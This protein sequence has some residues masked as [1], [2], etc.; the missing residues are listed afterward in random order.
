M[1]ILSTVASPRRTRALAWGILPVLFATLGSDYGR[2]QE[3]ATKPEAV[4]LSSLRL[5]KI[6][7]VV[8]GSVDRCEIAGAV[9]LV[10][11]HGQVVWLRANGQQDREHAK[12]MRTDSIF[13]ICSMTKPIV[14]L[15]VMLLYE[16]GRFQLDDPISKYIPEF[17]DP[18]VLVVP[19]EGKPYTIPATRPITIRHLLTHTS[20][21]TYN[22]D[23]VLGSDYKEAH[24]ASGLLP[25]E[26]TIGESVKRLARLPLLFHPG[27][28]WNYGL[29]IDV[30]GYLIEVVS[31]QPLDQFLQQ[32]I[33]EPLGMPDTFFYVPPDK[34]D[35]L[36][37]AYTWSEGK[38]LARFPDTPIT[39]GAFSYSAD[40][41]V[42]GPKKLFSGGAGL[43]STASDYARFCQLMLNHGKVGQTQRISR[44]SVELMTHDQLGPKF[45]EQAFGLGF[46]IDGVK[47]PLQELGSTG[48]YQWGGFFYTG[49]TIDPQEDLITVF[50]AQL[51]PGAPNTQ[52]KFHTLAYAALEEPTQE[53]SQAVI[54][55]R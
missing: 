49:F 22:W 17:A 42:R 38:G 50:M 6:A 3:L 12:P 25:F 32:R 47:T 24:I 16:E 40:Y 7:T 41:P 9:T 31:G 44:K 35:R 4:G 5:E 13:R 29:N 1:T 23:P 45:P 2:A 19:K 51:H 33:F 52:G 39:E 15:G 46:G 43:C 30:L 26:G 36:A 14:S 20:G 55:L 21:L 11:R 27:E 28:R 53:T 8:Q 37:T 10:A 54:R 34:L 18:K 48:Q